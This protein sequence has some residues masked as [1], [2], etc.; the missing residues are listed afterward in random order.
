MIKT[1]IDITEISRFSQMKNIEVFKKHVFTLRE[2]H[3][4]DGMKN[5]FNSIAAAFAAK[6]AFAKYMGSGFR[7]FSPRDI[8]ILHDE[9]GKPYILFMRK[10]IN[11]D[12]SL[13]HSGDCAVAVVCGEEYNMGRYADMI[14]SYRSMRPKR[15]PNINKGDCGRVLIIAGSNG[16]I[17][18]ACLCSRAA[19]RCGSGLVT[20]ALPEC[21]Q[22]TAAAKLDEVMTYPLPCCDKILT[23]DAAEKLSD[24]LTSCD[25]C[26]IGP[27]LGKSAGAKKILSAVLQNSAPCVIDA[28]GLNILAEDMSLLKEH[29][30]TV[31]LTPHPGEMSRL[32]GK[33]IKEIEDDRTSAATELA[34]RYRVYVVL[35]G[36]ETV[37]AAPDGE[38]HVNNS[39]NGGMASG[40]MGDVLTGVIASLLGQKLSPFNAAALGTFIHGL[41]G[42]IAAE[43][44]GEYGLIASDLIEKLP[45]TL[46]EL[47]R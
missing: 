45:L 15:R 18:A 24:K 26:A 34:A 28:D 37:I 31:I 5:P 41:A 22:P 14:K 44:K 13:S 33:S 4:F 32:T 1:G 30:C 35:K 19:M 29:R 21:I 2:R 39:G 6:E 10:P 16:M 7:G 25:V 36:H 12:V 47:A 9:L 23:E 17:G 43:E 3:Y 8:E 11:A 40:G 27:G 38:V 20:L 46:K 42:D